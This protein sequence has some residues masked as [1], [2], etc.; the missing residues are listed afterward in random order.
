MSD[1]PIKLYGFAGHA[2]LLDLSPFVA[3]LEA[4]LRLAGV[5]YEKRLGNSRKAP[6]G[7]LP[8]IRHG[9]QTVSDSQ[10]ILE[11]LAAQGLADLD[12][13]LDAEQRAE[14][15]ALR[16]MIENDLYFILVHTRWQT[17]AGWTIY[18]EVFGELMR[19][20]GV[21]GPLLGLVLRSARKSAVTQLVAQGTGR[22]DPDENLAH[23]RA[24]FAT[25][26]QFCGRREGPFWFGDAP[27]SLDAILHAFVG[28]AIVPN[29]G[30]AIEGLAEPHPRLRAWFEHVDAQV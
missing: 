7:K 21:P 18:R 19:G 3:K 10:R 2:G 27:S 28:G 13:Q 22:R 23:A 29:E 26:A 8:Y 16:S 30:L 25:L 6:R 9:E 1:A 12:A 17:E 15:F 4:Y 11:Y 14:V 24:I 5:A 20:A